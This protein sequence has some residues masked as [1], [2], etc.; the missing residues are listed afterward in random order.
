MLKLTITPEEIKQLQYERYNY[1][2]PRVQRKI[3]AIILK[4]QGIAHKTIVK[5]L[6]ICPN[7]LR[8]YF[9]KYQ[10]G[11]LEKLKQINYYIPQSELTQ[12]RQT[13]FNAKTFA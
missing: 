1:P 4:S 2:E 9:R 12:H 8:R 11:G 3:D 5:I 6:D 13:L 10:S 7:T